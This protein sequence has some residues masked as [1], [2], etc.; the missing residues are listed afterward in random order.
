MKFRTI[1]F[2]AGQTLLDYKSPMSEFVPAIL[3]RHGVALTAEQAA[4]AE[5]L[6]WKHMY[7]LQG[8]R[9]LK[10]SVAESWAFWAGVYEGIVDDMG[11][12]EP[13]RYAEILRLAYASTEAW[14]PF[15]D[16]TAALQGLRAHGVRMGVV[17]N[18]TDAL[19]GILHGLGM[20]QYFDFILTSAEIG[21]EKPDPAIFT[22]ALALT[23]VD[24]R[25]ILYVGDSVKHDL[26]SAAAAGMH[27]ALI[28]RHG[29]HPDAGCRRM[30]SLVELLALAEKVS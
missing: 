8:E 20:A 27:F 30:S 2:D 1:L 10:T 19:P 28:D 17:S 23:G 22:P 3:E 5:P 29:R 13:K 25:E 9:G 21:I 16:V 11:V 26:P 12:A 24:P 7:R 18:W 4:Q 14:A 15:A 6:M